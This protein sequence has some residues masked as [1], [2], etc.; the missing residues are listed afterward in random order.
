MHVH[1]KRLRK[2]K[3]KRTKDHCHP[4]KKKFRED[5][6]ITFSTHLDPNPE[7]CEDHH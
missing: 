2:Q 4:E 3:N 7:A 5:T 6:N 1:M